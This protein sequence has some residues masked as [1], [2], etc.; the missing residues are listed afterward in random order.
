MHRLNAAEYNNTVRDLFGTQLRLS[1]NFPPDDTA[2]GFD[3]IADALN[4]SDV[5]L[6]Y[7]IETAK[8]ISAEALSATRRAT[9][10]TCDL[11][12]EKEACVTSVLEELLPRAWRRPV[13]ADEIARLVTLYSTNKTDGATD[14]EALGRVLQAVLLAPEFLFRIEKNTG[15]AGVRSLDGYELASRLSYFLLDSMPDTEL[16]RAAASGELTNEAALATQVTRLLADTRSK[17]FSN[18]FGSQWLTIRS[19]DNVHPDAMEY[20]GFDDALRDAMREETM[21]FFAD[22]V[23]GQRPLRDLLTSTSGYVN[24]R[25]AK[26]Y[27]MAAVGSSEPVFTP[28]PANRGGLLRQASMLTVQAHPKESAPVLRG[29]WILSQLL[30]QPLPPPPPDVPQEPAPA[31]GQSRRERLAAHRVSP[32]CKT[33]HLNMDPL[34]LALE[35]FDGVGAYRTQ[36]NGAAIDPS[37]MLSDGSAFTTPAELGALI[38]ANPALPRCMA[39]Q[40]LTYALGR[41]PRKDDAFDAAVVDGVTRSFNDGGQLFPQLVSAIVKSPAFRTREDQAAQ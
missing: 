32:V 31:S 28:L 5:A 3:N 12:A 23:A 30:C 38:A 25:L 10:V 1:E 19:L 37:G 8:K 7:Y 2:Y 17:A 39:Q 26:H 24:D 9:L 22:I 6:G 15:V 11:K 20:P 33:C 29:K 14:D 21:H 41:G 36:E 16:T 40:L 27:G 13:A 34:G 18:S 35:Q 4:L